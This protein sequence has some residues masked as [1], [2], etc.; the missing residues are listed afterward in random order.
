MKNAPSYP[1]RIQRVVEYLAGH[2]DDTLDLDTVARLAHLSPYHFHR[3]YRGW[4]GETVGDTVRRLRL[5]RSAVDL[6]DRD[7]AIERVARRAGYASQAAFT[8]AFRDEYGEPPARYRGARRLLPADGERSRHRVEVLTLPGLRVAAI[9]Q[10]GDYRL[11]TK[12]FER[13]MTTAAM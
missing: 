13:L 3:V 8:R 10:R 6:L 1:A 5:Y 9:H 7:L 11:A 12:A 2:L 4:L